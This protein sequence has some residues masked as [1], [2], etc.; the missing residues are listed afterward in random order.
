[1]FTDD[2]SWRWCFYINLPI[3]GLGCAVIA[4]TFKVPEA[5]RPTNATLRE[6]LLQMD[7]IGTLTILAAIVCYILALQW[8]GITKAWSDSDVIGTLVGFGVLMLLFISWEWKLGDRSFIQPRFLKERKLAVMAA[9]MFFIAGPFYPFLYYLPIYFQSVRGVS[10]ASSGVHNLPFVIGAS[11]FSIVSGGLITAFGYYTPLMLL[12]AVL[13][14]VGA[15][16]LYTLGAHSGSGQWIGYQTIAGIGAGF[17]FQVRV[18]VSQASVHSSDMSSVQ[19]VMLFYQSLG[20]SIFLSAGQ[21]IFANR[22]LTEVTKHAPSV[23]PA[24]VFKTGATELR[25]VFSKDLLPAIVEAY[26]LGIKGTFA[27]IIAAAG[28]TLPIA[29]LSPWEKLLGVQEALAGGA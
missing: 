24:L 23:D 10:A 26:V 16:L 27:M 25:R 22:L 5:A 1:V 28:L 8:G 14:T 6:K 3:G 12:A 19:A 21:S 15:S 11:L 2:V 17:G 4:L 20:G 13:M 7:P 18:I 9:Y 29:L